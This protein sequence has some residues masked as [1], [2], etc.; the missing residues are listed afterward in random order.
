MHWCVRWFNIC[1]SWAIHAGA[2]LKPQCSRHISIE[3]CRSCA[4]CPVAEV[5]M[6]FTRWLA[7]CSGCLQESCVLASVA[8]VL[9]CCV[10]VHAMQCRWIWIRL[11]AWNTKTD[12]VVKYCVTLISGAGLGLGVWRRVAACCTLVCMHS[13]Y[14]LIIHLQCM[15]F[16]GHMGG[17]LMQWC[18]PRSYCVCF[19][20]RSNQAIL[21]LHVVLAGCCCLVLLGYNV[22]YALVPS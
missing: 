16:G 20:C 22:L 8:H 14:Y 4:P 19:C 5:L 1:W 2:Y 3:A 18:I 7:L 11:N 15:P 17:N 13:C 6:L 21:A 12:C 9:R 10:L